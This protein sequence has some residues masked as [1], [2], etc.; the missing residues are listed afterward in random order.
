MSARAAAQRQPVLMA[1]APLIKEGYLPHEALFPLVEKYRRHFPG[2]PP[3]EAAMM[4]MVSVTLLGR[5]A[6]NRSGLAAGASGDSEAPGALRQA[7]KRLA[8][9]QTA[10]DWI[11]VSACRCSSLFT[12]A[13]T[14]PSKR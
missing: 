14:R 5:M 11:S 7:K 9:V 4:D 3:D 13:S 6:E 10:G 12:A 1:L 2:L 8:G